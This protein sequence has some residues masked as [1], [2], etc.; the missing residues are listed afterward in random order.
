MN[1]EVLGSTC[2]V[3]RPEKLIRKP[4]V[5][6]LR[7]FIVV[8]SLS[9]HVDSSMSFSLRYDEIRGK[10]YSAKACSAVALGILCK[11]VECLSRIEYILNLLGLSHLEKRL[12]DPGKLFDGTLITILTYDNKLTVRKNKT[13]TYISGY[14]RL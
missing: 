9:V 10:T 5:L 4:I 13:K 6:S 8:S 11:A 3:L 12:G 2:V 14:A 7:N 1:N